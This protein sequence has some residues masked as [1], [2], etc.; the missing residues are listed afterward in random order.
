MMN[1]SLYQRRPYCTLRELTIKY[2]DRKL[3]DLHQSAQ[4]HQ[5]QRVPSTL[6]QVHRHLVPSQHFLHLPLSGGVRHRELYP[7]GKLSCQQEDSQNTL[8]SSLFLLL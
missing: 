7:E 8:W 6:H 3:A 2:R 5:R 4:E 1:H